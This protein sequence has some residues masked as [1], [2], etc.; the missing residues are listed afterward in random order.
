MNHDEIRDYGGVS[1][2]YRWPNL[3]KAQCPVKMR[4]AECIQMKADSVLYEPGDYYVIAAVPVFD[5]DGLR[6]CGSIRTYPGY[7]AIE[8]IKK[9]IEEMNTQLE[10]ASED[11]KIGFI[12]LNTCNNGAVI[13]RKIHETYHTGVKLPNGTTILMDED[14]VIGYIGEV[15]SHISIAMAEVLS[16]YPFIQI[17]YASTGDELSDRMSY[18]NFMRI[19]SPIKLQGDAMVNVVK[20]LDSNYVQIIYSDTVY[21]RDGRDEVHRAAADNQVCVIQ[22]IPFRDGD[23]PSGVYEKLRQHPHARIV[24]VFLHSFLIRDFMSA[25]VSA[26]NRG[27]FLFIGSQTWHHTGDLLDSDHDQVLLGSYSL[28]FEIG[29]D[30]Q[31]L[32]RIRN[33]TPQ[34]YRLNPWSMPFLQAR[35]DCYYDS[36]YDKTRPVHCNNVDKQQFDLDYL[37]S[38]AYFTTKALLKGA[39]S[40]LHKQC[41][42]TKLSACLS[43][44][45]NRQGT[46]Y[47][48]AYFVSFTT[49]SVFK[50]IITCTTDAAGFY[51]FLY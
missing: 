27:E 19:V 13:E 23:N 3:R 30:S 6:G 41:S 1:Q 46:F 8:A 32:Q 31:L 26:L 49:N 22:S 24:I 15:N 50:L 21:G 20:Y 42:P 2:E 43:F 36:S 25:I 45:K 39:T 38:F 33:L 9:A 44:G 11:L 14:K 16:Y 5:S 10:V 40:F 12:I 28:G 17:S 29:G 4:C 35:G 34:S 48:R 18:P 7:Q 47:V 37:D 51:I